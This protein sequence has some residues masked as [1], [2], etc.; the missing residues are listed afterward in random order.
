MKTMGNGGLKA[1]AGLL[2]LLLGCAPR[3][4][5][6]GSTLPEAFGGQGKCRVAASQNSPL[7]TEWPATE[8]AHLEALSH[9]GAVLVAYS[10]CSMRL[11]PACR[12]RGSYRWQRTTPS[13]DTL[14][15]GNE[16]EL[17]ARLPLGAASLEAELKRAGKLSVQ[18]TVAGQL[19][20]E[21]DTPP[22]LPPDGPCAQATHLVTALAVGAFT[23]TAGGN[24]SV[25]GS[26][27]IAEIGEAGGNR[28]RSASVMR[29]AGDPAVCG[30]ATDDGPQAN[31]ASPIQVFLSPLPGRAAE[32]GPPGAVK[33]DFVSGNPASRWDVYADDQVLCTTPCARWI[34]PHR[35]VMLRT[36]EGGGFMGPPSDRV[37]VPNLLAHAGQP[38]LQLQ[39]HGTATGRLVTGITFTALSGMAA[40]TGV[41]LTA[42]GCP[43]DRSALCKGGL[44][45]LGAGSLALIGSVYLILDARARAEVVPHGASPATFVHAP[46]PRLHLGPGLVAGTF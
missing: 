40:L 41:T 13:T 11:L 8:K 17:Y 10:G 12:V 39:A 19:R 3:L 1:A 29:S 32:E 16:D 5:S 24:A 22:T 28:S 14:E 26:A 25:R 42:L 31:C 30:A 2:L 37:Q 34:D 33:V 4:P 36:R 9:A 27:N 44:I 15:I 43:G 46:R 7:V 18:T 20:L 23:L 21:D 45:S 6:L 38:H 35:P